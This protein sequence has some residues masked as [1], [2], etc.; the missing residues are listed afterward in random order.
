MK[1]ICLAALLLTV[2]SFALADGNLRDLKKNPA[3]AQ[4]LKAFRAAKS[5]AKELGVSITE[6]C[7]N[8]DLEAGS[9]PVT[10]QFYY[11]KT[12]GEAANC[13]DPHYSIEV[14]FN[15]SGDV[16]SINLIDA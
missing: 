1:K 13:G 16:K 10:L 2:S 12:R 14:D 7:I 8:A 11:P 4:E 5:F 15:E 3:T 6:S 9:I